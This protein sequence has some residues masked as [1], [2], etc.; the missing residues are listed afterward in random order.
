MWRPIECV[1]HFPSPNAVL[2]KAFAC[3][4]DAEFRLRA[5]DRAP[6]KAMGLHRFTDFRHGLRA[7][8]KE[9]DQEIL[10]ADLA[11]FGDSLESFGLAQD[12]ASR[13]IDRLRKSHC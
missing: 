1:R 5:L 9:P 4:A 2:A 8:G 10:C 3:G 13:P 11:V 12:F 7:L 6:G